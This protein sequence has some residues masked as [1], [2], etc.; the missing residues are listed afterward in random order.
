[1]GTE[2]RGCVSA[3]E[4]GE[5]GGE[6][7][8]RVARP[9]CAPLPTRVRLG[10]RAHTRPRRHTRYSSSSDARS[11]SQL[12][13][14]SRMG[15][16]RW[17]KRVLAV[18]STPPA[19]VVGPPPGVGGGARM[20]VSAGAGGCISVRSAQP[21]RTSGATWEP[22]VCLS[23]LNESLCVCSRWK[24]ETVECSEKTHKSFLSHTHAHRT[25]AG[26]AFHTARSHAPPLP[27]WVPDG[28]PAAGPRPTWPP[29]TEQTAAP[30][31]RP[32]PR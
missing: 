5:E 19:A 28:E 23:L 25:G 12:A 2:S 32:M 20:G 7:R 4:T 8:R 17:A 14:K 24:G 3:P 26:R 18:R 13:A 30:P 10:E 16:S 15:C 21:R 27:P 6:W 11:T 31:R 9:E 1:M 22:G 29:E